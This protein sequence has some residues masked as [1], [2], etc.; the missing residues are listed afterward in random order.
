MGFLFYHLLKNPEKYM[1]VMQEVD[2]VVG[3]GPLTAQHLSKL[4]YLK[5]SIYEGIVVFSQS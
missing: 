2:E 3:T 1:K 4:V 5:Y